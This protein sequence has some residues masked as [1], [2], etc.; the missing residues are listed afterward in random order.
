VARTALARFG[1][2]QAAL[3]SPQKRALL[4]Q[5]EKL[6]IEIEKLKR[7][8][9]ALPPEDYHKRLQALLVALA[10]LQEEIER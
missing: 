10:N 8:K 9:A 3:A 6:E 1:A 4:A 5:R 2:A 7:E